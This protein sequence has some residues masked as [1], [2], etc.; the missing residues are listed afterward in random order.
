MAGEGGWL[1]K[2]NEEMH[3]HATE[4]AAALRMLCIPEGYWI[5]TVNL[6]ASLC[7][8]LGISG[9]SGVGKTLSNF[10]GS[11]SRKNMRGMCYGIALWKGKSSG[12]FML[13]FLF[14]CL[15]LFS[16][17]RMILFS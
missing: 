13:S 7:H 11:P 10:V 6:G 4:S 8:G 17:L 15:H 14:P 12:Y 5:L 3:C 2:R 1:V 9:V 16:S